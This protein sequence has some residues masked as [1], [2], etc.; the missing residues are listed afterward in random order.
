MDDF[1]T[2]YSS[3]SYL[4]KF[5]VDFIKI[6]RSFVCDLERNPRTQAL[7]EA[8][9]SMAHKLNIQVVAEGVETETQLQL[10]NE[11]NCNYAQG[12]FFS[13][14]VPANAF[15]KLSLKVFDMHH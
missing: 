14:P 11:M 2:G 1:G 9:I 4:N 3:L 5:Q 10:L 13:P 7:C 8:M 6:D 15:E 12:Y